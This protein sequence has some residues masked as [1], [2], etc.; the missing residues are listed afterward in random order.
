MPW[1]LV[2][3]AFK[4]TAEGAAM[5][6]GKRAVD[7]GIDRFECPRCRERISRRDIATGHCPRCNYGFSTAQIRQVEFER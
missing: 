6:V 1:H 7:A 2:G 4:W 5:E 3:L